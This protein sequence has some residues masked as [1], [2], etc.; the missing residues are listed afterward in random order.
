MHDDHP[1]IEDQT[2]VLRSDAGAAVNQTRESFPPPVGF[3]VD[4]PPWN[5][6]KVVSHTLRRRDDPHDSGVG[7]A[8]DEP[9]WT[10]QASDHDA[11]AP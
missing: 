1:A 7:A 9:S 10:R 8:R 6:R 5:I 3:P 4:A 2:T 11:T